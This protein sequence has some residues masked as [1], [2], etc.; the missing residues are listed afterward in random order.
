M[1]NRKAYNPNWRRWSKTAHPPPEP[2]SRKPANMR[3]E[4]WW[5][6]QTWDHLKGPA[7]RYEPV[8]TGANDPGESKL[9]PY[10]IQPESR[11]V[12]RVGTPSRGSNRGTWSLDEYYRM[13]T[14]L[15]SMILDV[16]KET[17]STDWL[18]ILAAGARAR[19]EAFQAR[20][21]KPS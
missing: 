2:V 10:F 8:C 9:V 17:I 21:A 15:D 1:A 11:L 20:A 16:P 5:F 7:L 18:W 12:I 6:L 13:R 14:Q 3:Q 19:L 4:D